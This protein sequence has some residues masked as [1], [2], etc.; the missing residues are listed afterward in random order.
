[1]AATTG[2]VSSSQL[3]TDLAK[4]SYASMFMRLWPNGPAP[5]WAIA[6]NMKTKTA[7]Q[8]EHGY[9]TKSMVFPEF[10]INFGAGYN[11]A[12]TAFVVVSSANIVPGQTFQNTRTLEIVRVVT[13]TDGTNIVVTRGFGTTAAAAINQSDYFPCVGSAYEEASDRPN[14][15]IILPTRVTNYT[16]IFRNSWAISDSLRATMVIAGEGNVAE[17]K[18]DCA[19]FHSSDMEKALL[20]G[21]KFTG[22][23]NG[24]PIRQMDGLI[25]SISTFAAG[26]IST[27]GATTTYTQLETALDPV[28]TFQSDPKMSNDRWLFCGG[29]ALRVINNIGRINGQYE[30]IDGQTSFGFQFKSFKIARGTFHIVEHPLLNTNTSF[31]KMAVAVDFSSMSLAYLAGRKTKSEEY[32]QEGENVRTPT[33]QD[34]VGG[35]LTTELTAE[36]MNPYANGVLYNL[37]AAAVG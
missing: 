5:I 15:S 21:Q 8:F 29:A 25:N 26:N 2:L 24:R 16:Q 28:F 13:V 37:T 10:T 30:I 14:S 27:M 7:L 32:G 34:S 12:A 11:A 3:P 19:L 33:G 9:Y 23:A 4:K 36:I 18:Q 35:S 6:A 22:T 17:S 20:F 1:M 31:S